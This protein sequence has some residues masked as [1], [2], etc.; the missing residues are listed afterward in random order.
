MN[1]HTLSANSY[2]IQDFFNKASKWF[3]NCIREYPFLVQPSVYDSSL[4][5]R[6]IKLFSKD[7]TAQYRYICDFVTPLRYP[8]SNSGSNLQSVHYTRQY[9]SRFVSL[10]P[11]T[12]HREYNPTVKNSKSLLL[13]LTGG[14]SNGRNEYYQSNHALFSTLV[15]HSV[16]DYCHVLVSL[17]L[18]V[19]Q[20][21]H[22]YVASGSV[23]IINKNHRMSVIPYYW[24]VTIEE[25]TS[26][27]TTKNS[28]GAVLSTEL[29][30]NKKIT[31]WDAM[32]NKQYNIVD[33]SHCVDSANIFKS[34]GNTDTLS[35]EQRDPHGL[36]FHEVYALYNHS[37][38][39]INAQMQP[40]VK[41]FADMK[42]KTTSF[43]S[44]DLN[45]SLYWILF[46]IHHSHKQYF[47]NT[48]N[49]VYP[50]VTNTEVIAVTG[51]ISNKTPLQVLI[52]QQYYHDSK[53]L[54]KLFDTG[55]NRDADATTDDG[56]NTGTKSLAYHHYPCSTNQLEIFIEQHLRSMIVKWR[57]DEFSCAGLGGSVKTEFD[58]TFN[59]LLQVCYKNQYKYNVLFFAIEYLFFSMVGLFH[60]LP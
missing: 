14:G 36:L 1:A 24:V 32:R 12:M 21:P 9:I 6:T 3:E 38:Y 57:C 46:P 44:F 58:A 42:T 50:A 18:G 20:T 27:P 52:Q 60:S 47:N 37:S 41:Q 25:S 22:V 34:V 19:M 53:R 17:L 10:L 54:S 26:I 15:C 51:S 29:N 31:F 45:N 28:N 39:Y 56:D 59:M 43:V 8:L 5:Q 48:V 4:P 35:E 30:I 23:K 16:L 49:M 13:G 55:T 33:T 7:E 2:N 11:N 40:T